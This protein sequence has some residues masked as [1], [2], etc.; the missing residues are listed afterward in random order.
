MKRY[1]QLP[2]ADAVAMRPYVGT[3][4][5]SIQKTVRGVTQLSMK[6]EV[7]PLAWRHSRT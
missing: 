1:Y 3:R 4:Y 5:T 2:L 7:R 6:V